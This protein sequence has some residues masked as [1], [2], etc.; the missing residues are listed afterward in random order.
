M[1]TSFAFPDVLLI[2]IEIQVVTDELLQ[3]NSVQDSLN[4]SPYPFGHTF[5][6]ALWVAYAWITR[7]QH[8]VFPDT[9]AARHP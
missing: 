5:G 7:L 9:T 8:G 3:R 2:L 1:P 4:E 6:T